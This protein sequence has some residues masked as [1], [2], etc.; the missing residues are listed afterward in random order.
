MIVSQ[1]ESYSL[2]AVAKMVGCGKTFIH[3]QV[4]KGLLRPTVRPSNGERRWLRVSRF[5]LTRWLLG[6]VPPDQVR[7]ILNPAGDLLLV[8]CPP[9]LQ[10][11]VQYISTWPT[12][13]VPS[14]FQLGRE[15]SVRRPWGVVIDLTQTGLNATTLSLR[16][17]ARLP[18]RP[19]LIGL[20][21]DDTGFA[22]HCFDVLLP[23]ALPPGKIAAKLM[24]LR[25]Q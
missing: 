12:V 10:S 18:D 11:A 25:P 8:S 17:Y 7:R 21:G 16:E 22:H 1:A 24:K 14:L 5:E 2:R 4:A 6:T 13:A 9:A 23:A 15:L 3:R 20:V 19:E